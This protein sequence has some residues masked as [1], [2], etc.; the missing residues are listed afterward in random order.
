MSK[1]SAST[2]A[3]SMAKYKTCEGKDN[4]R[5]IWLVMKKTTNTR[6][7]FWLVM[8]KTTNTRCIWLVMKTTTNTRCIWLIMEMTTHDVLDEWWKGQQNT[9][10]LTGDGKD[11]QRTMY[12]T[13]DGEDNTRCIARLIKRAACPL[14]E[15]L[16]V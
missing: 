10:Y 9:M 1:I 16:Y 2:N 5:Y 15:F 4:T 14:N 3:N 12:M 8:E 7:I 11:T 13:S 6:C